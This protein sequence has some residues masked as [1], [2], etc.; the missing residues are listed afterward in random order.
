MD[1]QIFPIF[2]KKV[3]RSIMSKGQ[4]NCHSEDLQSMQRYF[5]CSWNNPWEVYGYTKKF[6][7]WYRKRPQTKKA[8]TLFAN[9]LSIYSLTSPSEQH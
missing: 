8:I 3:K 1:R 5:I 4:K 9:S 6:R 2:P 7:N